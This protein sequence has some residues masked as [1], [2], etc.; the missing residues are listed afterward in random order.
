MKMLSKEWKWSKVVSDK[1]YAAFYLFSVWL[2][3]D[4]QLKIFVYWF[5]KLFQ[6]LLRGTK[7]MKCLHPEISF[8]KLLLATFC[9]NVRQNSEC[10][11]KPIWCSYALHLDYK[12]RKAGNCYAQ[13]LLASIII[14]LPILLAWSLT[15]QNNAHFLQVLSFLF[16]TRKIYF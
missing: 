6:P 3:W 2:C 4:F 15:N 12:G 7:K 10:P 1:I 14:F 8:C 9:K 5:K 11:V 16:F 13:R